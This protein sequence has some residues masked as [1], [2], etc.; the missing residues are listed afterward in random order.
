M[1]PETFDL[2]P[3]RVWVF[4]LDDLRPHFDEWEQAI[5]QWRAQDRSQGSSNRMGWTSAKTVFE[6]AQF[7]PLEAAIRQCFTAAYADAALVR[8]PNFRMT[9]WVNLQDP[10]GFNHFHTHGKAGLAGAFYLRVPQGSGEIVFRDPRPGIQLVGLKGNGVN[11]QS[12][13]SHEPKEGEFVVFPGWLEHAVDVNAANETRI[14]IAV[15]SYL[16]SD[17]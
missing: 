6:H 15:N 8:Q 7:S 17:E 10:G 9:A 5:A 13:T 2:F 16:E 11:C 4:R 1:Q 3:T 14:S 12:V